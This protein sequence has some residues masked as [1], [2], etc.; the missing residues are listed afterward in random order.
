M[1]SAALFA[2]SG[3]I[4]LCSLSVEGTSIP[5]LDAMLVPIATATLVQGMSPGQKQAQAS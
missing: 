5:E 2:A 3:L 4:A 1:I